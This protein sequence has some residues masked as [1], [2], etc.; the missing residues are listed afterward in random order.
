ML[1]RI[2]KRFLDGF[3][4][5]VLNMETTGLWK[6]QQIIITG[7]L[8]DPIY[9]SWIMKNIKSLPNILEL[10]SEDVETVLKTQPQAAGVL[11][12]ALFS[13]PVNQRDAFVN[14]LPKSASLLQDEISYLSEVSPSEQEGAVFFLLKII[15]KLQEEELI[16]GF[17]WRLPPMDIFYPK[18]YEDGPLK[19]FFESG[20]LAAEGVMSSN[21]RT[22][23]WTHYYDS[24]KILARGHYSG[25]MKEGNWEF[26][27]GN[28]K[29]KS[30]GMYFNDNKSGIW[31]EWNR[32]DECVEMIFRDGVRIDNQSSSK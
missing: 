17:G 30:Q 19:I 6:R 22:G 21:R 26:F 9:M 31:K 8:E 13:L 5:F 25:G 29:P 3:K 24:G 14:S 1:E 12:R 32:Q 7:I 18:Q 15:R 4:D 28:G 11:A 2:K 20:I 10:N 27:F 16:I 23:A